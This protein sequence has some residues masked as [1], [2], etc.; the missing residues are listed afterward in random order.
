LVVKVEVLIVE[1]LKV[2]LLIVD[3]LAVI[4]ERFVV[5]ILELI[6]SSILPT[7]DVIVPELLIVVVF[8]VVMVANE[9]IIIDE[10]IV[11]ALI[12][13]LLCIPVDNV[14]IIPDGVYIDVVAFNEFNSKSVV[15]SI[16][17]FFGCSK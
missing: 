15:V 16:V 2:L 7:F 9:L 11:E 4:A 3:I 12:V 13:E 1:L 5:S 17:L 10:L 14:S 8:N 6:T